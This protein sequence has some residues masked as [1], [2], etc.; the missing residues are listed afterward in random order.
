[1][2]KE[3]IEINTLIIQLASFAVSRSLVALIY[4]TYL[5]RMG[6]KLHNLNL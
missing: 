2:S 3:V 5:L 4:T 1:M 6:D